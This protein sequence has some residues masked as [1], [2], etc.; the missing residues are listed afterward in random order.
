MQVGDDRC[1][2]SRLTFA[3]QVFGERITNRLVGFDAL[4]AFVGELK[5]MKAVVRRHDVGDLSG[6]EQEANVKDC[7]HLALGKPAE[8]AAHIGLKAHREF[9]GG[10]LGGHFAG[11]DEFQHVARF[12]GGTNQDLTGPNLLRLFRERDRGIVQSLDL[13]FRDG[14]TRTQTLPQ[15]GILGQMAANAVAK[16]VHRQ[17]L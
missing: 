8:V 10:L 1:D 5:N 12:F 2:R 17:L 3:H 4:V 9:Y 7:R 15:V 14:R 13:G 11:V 16:G 6:C